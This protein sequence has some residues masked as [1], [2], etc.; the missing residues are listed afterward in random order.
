MIRE[1]KTDFMSEF[2]EK[3]EL[4]NQQFVPLLPFV[5]REFHDFDKYKEYS[6]KCIYLIDD[7]DEDYCLYH[8]YL[9]KTNDA[10]RAT[11]IIP[12]DYGRRFEILNRSMA[13]V[14]SWFRENMT[15][16]QMIIQSLEYGEIEYYP[17]L[18]HYIIGPILANGFDPKY[19]MYMK[20]VIKNEIGEF[21]L[22]EDMI[23]ESYSEDIH[24]EILQFYYG[25]QRKSDQ[26]FVSCTYEEFNVFIKDEFTSKTARF[27]RNREGQII[28]GAI[29]SKGNGRVWI[30]N[31]L[32]DGRYIG[33]NVGE[34]LLSQLVVILAE[35]CPEEEV[36][37]I[38]N[39]RS[40]ALREICEENGFAAIEFWV[41]MTLER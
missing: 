40:K 17:T 32:V 37:I 39:R 36:Y 15:C 28:A 18:S 8:F 22:K 21:T 6:D 29:I 19:Y 7:M 26:F 1:I 9:D 41:D 25:E 4:V 12:S 13:N 27:V 14:V 38:S 33:D 20:K 5:K 34:Y 31:L 10:L 35:T 2:A 23:F 11:L 24:D 30:D 3:I 16:K